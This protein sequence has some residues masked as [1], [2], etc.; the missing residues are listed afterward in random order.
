[1]P[2]SQII[3]WRLP[4]LSTYSAD[5]SVSWMV[6]IMLRLRNTG[7]CVL[8]TAVSRGKFWLLRA[9]I[10]NTSVYLPTSAT[11]SGDITSVMTGRPVSS[12]ASAR[13]SS[14]SSPMPWNA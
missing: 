7:R 14:P 8:P 13:S 3:T 4:P 6:P 9:P 12:R 10:W 1:M 5:I 11:V 2:R